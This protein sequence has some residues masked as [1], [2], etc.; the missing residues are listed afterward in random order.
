MNINDPSSLSSLLGGFDEYFDANPMAITLPASRTIAPSIN[1]LAHSAVPHIPGP[2]GVIAQRLAR[3]EAPV[4]DQWAQHEV[5]HEEYVP[6]V[7]DSPAWRAA[8]D[9][10][11][12]SAGAYVLTDVFARVPTTHRRP[13]HAWAQRAQRAHRPC[14]HTHSAA[15]GTCDVNDNHR[16]WGRL[17]HYQ[18]VNAPVCH[19]AVSLI[20]PQDSTA[21]MGACI[22]HSVL[23]QPI[24]T[25]AAVLLQDVPVLQAGH[26]A[27]YLCVTPSNVMQLFLG[28]AQSAAASGKRNRVPAALD[29]AAPSMPID[30]PPTNQG[31]TP[32]AAVQ[33]P[34]QPTHHVPKDQPALL[35]AVQVPVRP[36][37]H[38]V[39]KHQAAP[40][41]AVQRPA[42]PPTHYMPKDQPA[43]LTAVQRPAQPPTSHVPRQHPE[44]LTVVQRPAQPPT[45]HV[46]RPPPPDD[47][48]LAEHRM[49][50]SKRARAACVDVTNAPPDSMQLGVDS[51]TTV[52]AVD[53]TVPSLNPS[54]VMVNLPP[55]G[56]VL[57]LS[58]QLSLF[59][60]M[61]AV[62]PTTTVN[63][64]P[65][66]NA[67][68]ISQNPAP[69]V[70]A[71]DIMQL[72]DGLDD[73][74]F[75]GC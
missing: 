15:V 48:A 42:Q 58:D 43:P 23:S 33:R 18:G 28:D 75:G 32:L 8:L 17:C 41:T 22:H 20:R 46:P 49:R 14:T 73:A 10:L 62:K 50:R 55:L 53:S 11:D 59:S 51:T 60:P 27:R 70:L 45:N 9:A 71:P 30:V 68:A 39:P 12:V 13:R 6:G 24:A 5:H 3:G 21:S 26:A 61:Q 67:Q 7:E 65:P 72:M 54:P 2:A 44:S 74:L 19:T 47:P 4:S 34:V 57:P 31:L 1:T 52:N 64:L 36:P 40:L 37:T 63:A 29:T 16:R 35:T 25:G 56:N 69:P 38:H 66:T